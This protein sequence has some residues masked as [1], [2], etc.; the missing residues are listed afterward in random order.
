[1]RF[2]FLLLVFAASGLLTMVAPVLSAESPEQGKMS[3]KTSDKAKQSVPQL[4]REGEL[5]VRLLSA[6]GLGTADDEV[7]AESRLADAGVAPRNG[8]VANYPVTPDIIGELYKSVRD[9]AAADRIPMSIEAAL[10]QLSQV[11]NELGLAVKPADK[12]RKSAS[13]E[14]GNPVQIDESEFYAADG[15]PVVSYYRPPADYFYL[16]SWVPYP[17]WWSGI[18][19]GGYYILNDFHRPH[20]RGN[21]VYFYSNH[22]NDIRRHRVFRIDPY[23]RYRGRTYYGIGSSRRG[24]LST[25]VPHSGRTIFNG[26]RSR[27]YQDNRTGSGGDSGQWGGRRR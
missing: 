15:P 11:I 4:V 6:L 17:F 3:E 27:G 20:Y 24:G 19:F 23:E 22:Y 9:A 25:G 26:D 7:A 5:A 18:W 1:M 16:Y 21:R 2:H 12:D 14:R 13:R 8:W 10:G